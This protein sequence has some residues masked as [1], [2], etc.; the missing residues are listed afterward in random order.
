M[1]L[2]GSKQELCDDNVLKCLRFLL[3][4]KLTTMQEKI[5]RIVTTGE[6]EDNEERD[7]KSDS[8]V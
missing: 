3:E 4:D 2:R 7:Q 8:V 5:A 6:T 1:G